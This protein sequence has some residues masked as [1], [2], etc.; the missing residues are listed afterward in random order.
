[1]NPYEPITLGKY[2]LVE[3][4]CD[5]LPYNVEDWR[6]NGASLNYGE[7]AFVIDKAKGHEYYLKIITN[8]GMV[9]WIRE[10]VT[11]YI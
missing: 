11:E 5:Y 9:G 10:S 3:R 8:S 1:M 7:I 6:Y 4:L 2:Y